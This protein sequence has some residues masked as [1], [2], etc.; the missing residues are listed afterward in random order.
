MSLRASRGSRLLMAAALAW[1]GLALCA[2]AAHATYGKVQVAKINQGG[3]PSDTFSFHPTLTPSASDFSLKGGQ[4]SSV[5]QIECNIDRTNHVDECKKWGYPALKFTEQAKPGYT[6][7]DIT[8][9]FTQGSTA[10]GTEP[11][12]S[13][14]VKPASEV[15]KDLANG[16]VS[17]KVHW[18]EWVK[19]WYTNTKQPDTGTIKV[20]KKLL[21]A[22]DAGKFNLQVDGQTKAADV[23]DGGTTGTQTVTTGAHSVGETAGTGT[24]LADYDAATSCV[25][26]AHNG[27]ADTDGS[28]TVGKGDA[29]ECTITNTRKPPPPPPPVV[30]PTQTP[31][32]TTP[33][34]TTVA[35]N[36]VSPAIQ[37]NPARVRPGSAVLRGPHA[38][39]TTNV[40]AAT[41]TGKRIVKVTFYLDG[42]KVKTLTKPNKGS[43][44]VLPLNVRRLAYG[45]HRVQ[46]KVQFAKA[47]GTKA[48]TMRL[49]FSR[50]GAAAAQPQFTG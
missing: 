34:T 4:S 42:K 8:C 20:I 32:T 29:W 36:A 49:S 38:C 17:L 24:N 31:P 27:P 5:L 44:W 3:N 13:S 37:V 10:F 45:S 21:P 12:T 7:T 46:A 40:V 43:G 35:Q 23:G 39:P 47:S 14:P 48:K 33:P 6:L 28:L 9:R 1:L 11:T 18:Y 41:V 22:T 26:T 15:T 50:C 2:Q 19:C 25:D 30:P 16:T